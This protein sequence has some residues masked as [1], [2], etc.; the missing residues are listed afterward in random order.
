MSDPTP[1][2]SE[3]PICRD[4][5]N[6]IDTG[7]IPLVFVPGVM[8]SRLHFPEI[9]E[10]WDPDSNWAMSH[11]LTSSAETSRQEFSLDNPAEVMTDG[12][13]LSSIQRSRGWGGVSWD[14][15]GT[16]VRHLSDEWFVNYD[17]PVYVI[18]YDWRQDNRDSGN[19]VAER[20]RWILED[21]GADR[22]ILISH[23]MGGLVT[24][25]CLKDHSDVAE[26]LMGVIHIAQPVCGGVVLVRRMFTG[27]L[28]EHD[29]GKLFSSILGNTRK[30]ALTI[31]SGM[32]GPLQL[33]VTR[34]Y[35]DTDGSWW[36]GY[37]TFEEPDVPL[38]WEGDPWSLYL[39]QQS[40]PG[41]LPPVGEDYAP[42][43]AARIGLIHRI[44]E[45]RVFHNWL[46]LW[47]HEKTW[48]INSTGLTVDMRLDF[49]LPP[50]VYDDGWFTDT[51][52]RA[53]GT[54]VEIDDPNPADRGNILRR[55]SR[56][57]GT[58]PITSA[59]A[60]FRGQR[61]AVEI[62]ADYDTKRQFRISGA[63]HDAICHHPDCERALYDIIRH[64]L[65]A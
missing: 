42:I 65:G 24:R 18:G 7:T 60:L 23:S 13:G 26:K 45:A 30:K 10:Q 61:H 52:T 35:R 64:I 39:E 38:L 53:D 56:S 4:S 48:A 51:A 25:S 46:G 32:P 55:R 63:A 57:D 50:V 28:S 36:Y 5:D 29:G 27:A 54:E 37:S 43:M 3:Q 62:G 58:V 41:L 34:H 49:E 15:Y 8:G 17:T 2:G 40:P 22:F 21:A 1:S 33:L 59:E 44:I 6:T 11:W 20:I 31:A 16:F 14:F 12:S 47:K 9:D 19:A